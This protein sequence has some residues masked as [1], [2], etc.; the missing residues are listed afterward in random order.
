M[1]RDTRRQ[2]NE[3]INDEI[4]GPPFDRSIVR[5]VAE[6]RPHQA[7]CYVLSGE[8]S[9]VRKTLQQPDTDARHGAGQKADTCQYHKHAHT[10]WRGGRRPMRTTRH[11]Y[12]SCVSPDWAPVTVSASLDNV[13]MSYCGYL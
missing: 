10:A 6:F 7:H 3:K 2:Q 1:G 11:P 8:I 9:Q 12:P 5:S 13:V 4:H